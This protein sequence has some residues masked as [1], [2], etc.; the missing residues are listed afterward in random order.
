[1]IGEWR[2]A[3]GGE[4]SRP[5]CPE[6]AVAMLNRGQRRTGGTVDAWWR[7]CAGHLADYGKCVR[8]GQVAWH[9]RQHGRPVAVVDTG[10]LL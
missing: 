7:Y 6:P 1:M 2:A 4:C 8:D 9:S 3:D 5:H 10:G